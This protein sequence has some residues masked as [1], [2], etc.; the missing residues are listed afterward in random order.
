MSFR[1]VG[2]IQEKRAYTLPYKLGQQDNGFL[3]MLQLEGEIEPR[4]RR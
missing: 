2:Q 1:Q 4:W 3:E